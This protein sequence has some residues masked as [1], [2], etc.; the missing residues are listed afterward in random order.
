MNIISKML[1]IVL[2][3]SLPSA[4]LF[5]EDYKYEYLYKDLPFAM[6]RLVVPVFPDRSI[7]ID[8]I[9]GVG[10]G[11]TLNTEAFKKAIDKLAS[12]GGGTVKVPFGVWL[13]GQ[14]GRASCRERV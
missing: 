2:M 1:I 10:D 3:I 13:T 5:S 12:Q 6:P 11:F 4:Y 14:I 8:E 7:S 9:G